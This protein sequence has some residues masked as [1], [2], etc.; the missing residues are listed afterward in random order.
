MYKIKITTF[1]PLFAL[2]IMLASC[3]TKE[4]LD[5]NNK[6]VEAQKNLVTQIN[7]TQK[8]TVN[9][10]QK[11]QHIQDIAKTKLKEI[12]ALKEP[13]DGEAFKQAMEDDFQGLIDSYDVWIQMAK[14]KGNTDIKTDVQDKLK[15]W[16]TKITDLDNKVKDEQKKFADKHN[17]KLQ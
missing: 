12:S 1:I 5:F 13:S 2:V 8:D 3:G 11:L 10:I 4:A 9:A 16:E 14:E 15:F 6:L 17:I 7:E